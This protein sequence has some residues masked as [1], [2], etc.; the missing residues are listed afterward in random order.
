MLDEEYEYFEIKVLCGK[1]EVHNL[2]NELLAIGACSV[3][4]RDA[5]DVPILE[6][7]PGETPLW[8]DMEVTGMFTRDHNQKE[9]LEKIKEYCPNRKVKCEMLQNQVW[10][11]TWLEHFKPMCFG[12]ETWIIPSEFEVVDESAINIHLDPGLA[13]GTGSHAT[14]ALCLDWVDAHDMLQKRIIDFGCGSGILAIAALKHGARHVYCTDIDPQAIDSTL[15]NAAANQVDGD[16]IIVSAKEVPDIEELDIIM[17]NILVAP[18]IGLVNTFAEILKTN[19]ELIMSGI[20]A[21]QTDEIIEKY[22]QAFVDFEVK[23]TDDWA[24]VYCRKK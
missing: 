14:T 15:I 10:E 3:T 1:L 9:I 23:I 12:K 13:F 18:L 7:A 8:E 19:G 2:E 22:S 24:S 17:A 6:P 21:E 20:L 16:I 5:Q 11:R 4:Y